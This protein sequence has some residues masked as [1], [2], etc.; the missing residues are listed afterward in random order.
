MSDHINQNGGLCGDSELDA[1]A[2]S[3]TPPATPPSRLHHPKPDPKPPRR[4]A[5]R[6]L[7]RAIRDR[8]TSDINALLAWQRPAAALDPNGIHQMRRATRRLRAT[9]R[10]FRPTLDS[11][12]AGSLFDEVR[13]LAHHL[14][15]VRDLDVVREELFGPHPDAPDIEDEDNHNPHFNLLR[16]AFD[17]NH[18]LAR[19]ALAE[20]LS[21]R[22]YTVLLD[23]LREAAR[24]PWLKGDAADPARKTL[25]RR[26]KKLADKV[27]NAH[28]ALTLEPTDEAYHRLRRRAKDLR[29]GL[30]AAAPDIGRRKKVKRLD[31]R[32]S[33]LLAML[34]DRQDAVVASRIVEVL[35][36]GLDPTHPPELHATVESLIDRQQPIILDADRQFPD[37]WR[38]ARRACRD[39]LDSW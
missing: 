6:T 29:L 8:L 1:L 17:E 9:L 3:S 35:A 10:L 21:S 28:D 31:I 38:A 19:L 15:T 25:R 20:T 16:D 36:D 14:G 23:K 4:K 2:T 13:W 30:D 22:R 33:R 12:W 7:S 27:R 39:L 37:A 34:G 11:L 32:L 26:V 18:R 5:R 24:H